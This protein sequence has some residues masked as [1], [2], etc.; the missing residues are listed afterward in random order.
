M[1]QKT[2]IGLFY[3]KLAASVRIHKENTEKINKYK[4]TRSVFELGTTDNT[5]ATFSLVASPPPTPG[6]GGGEDC[7]KKKLAKR[8]RVDNTKFSMYVTVFPVRF[9]LFLTHAHTKTMNCTN[10]QEA[11][12]INWECIIFDTFKEKP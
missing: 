5:R 8:F 2:C 12:I 11:L 7:W 6:G 10:L 3:S 4:E 9:A 1:T